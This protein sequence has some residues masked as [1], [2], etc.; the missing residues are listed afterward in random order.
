MIVI[1]DI[2][3]CLDNVARYLD[4]QD[5]RGPNDIRRKLVDKELSDIETMIIELRR[6]NQQRI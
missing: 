2:K 5:E 6:N 1:E 4:L 3:T